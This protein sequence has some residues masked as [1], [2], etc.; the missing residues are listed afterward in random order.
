MRRGL[1]AA[2]GAVGLLLGVLALAEA[3]AAQTQAPEAPADI[4]PQ[5]ALLDQYCVT[6]HNQRIVDGTAGSGLVVD[7]LSSARSDPRHR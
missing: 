3:P 7:Q 1:L 5:R 2:V 4:S 6:C